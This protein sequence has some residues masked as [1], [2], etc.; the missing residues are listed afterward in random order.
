MAD[1]TDSDETYGSLSD[2]AQFYARHEANRIT[3]RYVG[4]PRTAPRAPHESRIG[5][6]EAHA[7]LEAAR[8]EARRKSLFS[9][10][11]ADQ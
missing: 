8:I 2:H 7:R 4:T 9:E 5:T 3:T 11:S 1:R 10:I 6:D